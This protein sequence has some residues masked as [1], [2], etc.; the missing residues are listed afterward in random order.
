MG[1]IY[2]KSRG[3]KD[4]RKWRRKKAQRELEKISGDEHERYLSEL[5][6][7]YIL[8]K[9][10]TEDAGYYKGIKAVAKKL[11]QKKISI[12]IISQTTGLTKEEIEKL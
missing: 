9:K 2:R 10:A 8:D 1:E 5:R 7:K 6:E 3:G 4:G 11:L 12:D